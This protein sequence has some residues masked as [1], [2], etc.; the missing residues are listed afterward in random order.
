VGQSFQ[1]LHR[2]QWVTEGSIWRPPTTITLHDEAGA[3]IPSTQMATML[4]TLYDLMDPT[5]P[6]V[7]GVNGTIDVKNARSCTLSTQGVFVLTLLPGDTVILDSTRPYEM[8]RAL[9][10]YEWPTTPTKSDA[11]EVTFV[12]RNLLKRP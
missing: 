9:V 5:H 7:N 10:E 4:M 12:V 11:L 6:I 1:F 3:V 8:R 2:D